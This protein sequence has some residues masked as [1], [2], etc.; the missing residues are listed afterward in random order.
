MAAEKGANV[1]QMD[2]KTAYLNAKLKE[3]IFIE[4]PE[5]FVKGENMVCHLKRAMYGLKHSGREWYEELSDHLTSLQ[6]KAT[7]QD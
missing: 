4:Q 6:F 5:G 3:D 1:Y 7:K 2:I